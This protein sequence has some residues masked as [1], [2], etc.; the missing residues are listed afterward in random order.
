MDEVFHIPQAEQYLNGNFSHWDPKITTPPALYICGVLITYIP[1]RHFGVDGVI[2]FRGVNLILH[3]MLLVLLHKWLFAHQPAAHTLYL[4]PPLF[5]CQFLFYTDVLS[6]VLVLLCFFLACAA[7]RNHRPQ[8]LHTSAAVAALAVATRQPN[9]VWAAFT[10]GLYTCLRLGVA[11]AT[12]KLHVSSISAKAPSIVFGPCRSYILLGLCFIVLVMVNGGLALGDKANHEVRPHLA[13][14]VYFFAF[15]A[16][17]APGYPLALLLHALRG[18][19]VPR[20]WV[21][22]AVLALGFGGVA[23]QF[24]SFAHPFVLADNRHY[25]F[26]LWR[27]VLGH[28]VHRYTLLLPWSC[29]GVATACACLDGYSLLV[30][31]MFIGC[32]SACLATCPLVEFRY[33]IIPHALLYILPLLRPPTVGDLFRRRAHQVN[34]CAGAVVNAVTLYLFLY[35][36]FTAPDGTEGRFMW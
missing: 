11:G 3:S 15:F 4:L 34:A 24:S 26:Y 33:F 28:E 8:L 7:H 22:A 17:S 19:V 5:F 23:L 16:A 10:A 31:A 18:G 27:R 30:R 2:A 32:L 1:M 12:D 25:V 21:M 9:I 36:P 14:L 6:T 29:V 13:Q 35:R 20:W